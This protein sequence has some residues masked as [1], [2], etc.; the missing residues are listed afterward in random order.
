MRS[1]LVLIPAYQVEASLRKLVAGIAEQAPNT[2]ALIVNDGSTDGTDGARTRAG[3]RER[4]CFVRR[5]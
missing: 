3:G 2:H 1:I 4:G 5:A